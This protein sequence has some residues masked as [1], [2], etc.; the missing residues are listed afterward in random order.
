MAAR[1]LFVSML[2]AWVGGVILD[3]VV[4]WQA[5]PLWLVW[6][7]VFLMVAGLAAGFVV[8]QKEARRSRAELNE[9][10][11]STERIRRQFEQDRAQAKLDQILREGEQIRQRREEGTAPESD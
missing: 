1:L 7:G 4:W 10:L 5:W 8:S 11:W 6:P 3:L 9:M 2:A